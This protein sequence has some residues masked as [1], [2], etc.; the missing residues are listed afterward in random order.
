MEGK[1]LLTQ[2]EELITPVIEAMGY[3]LWGCELHMQGRYSLLRV[4]IDVINDDPKVGVS[5][6]DCSRV[7]RQV[8]AV[9]DVE[10]LITGSY[11]LELSSPGL[12]R[13]LFKLEHYQ[14]F[15]GKMA[16]IC[17]WSKE[18]GQKNFTGVIKAATSETVT[19]ISSVDD[20]IF[21]IA[22]KNIKKANLI[23]PS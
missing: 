4:Y 17:L 20:E 3:Q 13:P 10:D 8:S 18:H 9:L 11:S 6:D 7:S 16:H 23:Y 12:E 2:V 22:M 19:I 21:T 5:L 14:R 15:L 1:K